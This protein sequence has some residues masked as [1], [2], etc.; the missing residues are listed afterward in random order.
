M[1]EVYCA[2]DTRLHRIDAVKT[3]SAHLEGSA[4][5]I[6]RFERE[7]RAAAALNHPNI[8]AIYDAGTSPPFIAMEL[9]QGETLQQRLL[10]GRMD[11]GEVVDV[12]LAILGSMR[13]R[14]RAFFIAISSPR[15]SS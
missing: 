8:C 2:E 9:L 10:R 5:A 15:T 7:A 4:P 6:E 1:E 3:L 11:V 12:T 13:P 14:E